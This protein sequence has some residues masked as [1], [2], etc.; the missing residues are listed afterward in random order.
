VDLLVAQAAES[1]RIWTGAEP[2]LDVMRTAA[3]LET[4]AD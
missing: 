2:P 1:F 4:A 3:R